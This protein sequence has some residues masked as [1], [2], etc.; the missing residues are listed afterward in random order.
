MTGEMLKILLR[1]EGRRRLL[2]E[3]AK[4]KVI[5]SS[6]LV[7]RTGLRRQTVNEYI[8]EFEEAGLIAVKK[9]Q[10]PW[11]IIASDELEYLI[12]TLPVA[13]TKK[14]KLEYPCG[15]PDF[16]RCLFR[17]R[18]L[19]LTFIWGARGLTAAKAHDAVGVPEFVKEMVL[20]SLHNGVSEHDLQIRSSLDV[21]A[22]LDEKLL[23]TNLVLIGAG[24]V[25][26]LTAKVIEVLNPPIRFEPPMGREIVSELTDT[27]YTAGDEVKRNAALIALLPNPWAEDKIILLMGGIF[28]HGTRAA[29]KAINR[30]LKTPFIENHEAGVPL[31]VLK[32]TPEGDFDRFF[33]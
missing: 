11:I 19:E 5:T 7:R 31:R 28:K 21:E 22:A 18:R 33:E 29:I 24:I 3:I 20:L 16:P 8:K 12:S 17:D 9:T 4:E 23:R 6:E 32:A 26:L 2:T 15:W 10:R 30:H 14:V 25:N 27:I 1:S 13:S